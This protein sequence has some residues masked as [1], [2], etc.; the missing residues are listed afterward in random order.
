MI[1]PEKMSL[2]AHQHVQDYL[3]GQANI[4]DNDLTAVLRLS[5]HLRVFGL[6]SAVGYINQTNDQA[7]QVRERTVPVW[8]SLLSNLILEQPT[9]DGRRLMEV[10]VEMARNEPVQYMATWRK[11]LIITNHWNFWARAYK[12]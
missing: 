8:R 2:M 11:S 12:E 3:G 9:N 1:Q 5:Q 4:S 7:G 10:V 6:L